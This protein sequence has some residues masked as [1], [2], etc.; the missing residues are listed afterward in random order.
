SGATSNECGESVAPN[1]LAT[2]VAQ[3]PE[4]PTLGERFPLTK[5]EWASSVAAR[6]EAR[7]LGMNSDDQDVAAAMV[8]AESAPLESGA[9]LARCQRRVGYFFRDVSILQFALTH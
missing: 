6:G 7:E 9:L 5:G 2:R 8:A 1:Q 4:R 3:G